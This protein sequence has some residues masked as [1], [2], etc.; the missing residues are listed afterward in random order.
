MRQEDKSIIKN[1]SL[2]EI[3]LV[4]LVSYI[5]ETQFWIPCQYIQPVWKKN[6]LIK[7]LVWKR[8]LKAAICFWYLKKTSARQLR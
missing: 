3:A 6:Y 8:I 7:F 1:A 2:K 4:E 5:F